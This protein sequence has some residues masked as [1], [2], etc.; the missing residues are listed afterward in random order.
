MSHL[1]FSIPAFST[2][3]CPFKSDLSGNT[4]WLQ[5]SGFPKVAKVAKIDNFGH[6]W[7]TF[8]HSNCKR[9]SLRLHCWMRLLG[10]FSNTVCIE[11]KAHWSWFNLIEAVF[12]A[13]SYD[14]RTFDMSFCQDFLGNAKTRE[15]FEGFERNLHHLCS[16][17][18][19]LKD[20]VF[21]HHN[22]QLQNFYLRK[23]VMR[24]R[25]VSSLFQHQNRER[26]NEP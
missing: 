6:F 2:N 25:C 14:L 12:H 22:V 17:Q 16:R 15:K 5:A 26:Q 10:P 11:C 8:V 18:R 24:N 7:W 13:V 20:F 23:V 4:V 21:L 3:L 9:S 1:N 19:R